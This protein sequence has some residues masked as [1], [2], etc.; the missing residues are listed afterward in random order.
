M[1]LIL[2]DESDVSTNDVVNWLNYFSVYYKR[3]NGNSSI[4][5][6]NIYL[7]DEG[8]KWNLTITENFNPLPVSISSDSISQFWYRRG[9][10]S[11]NKSLTIS[12]NFSPANYQVI[13]ELQRCINDNQNDVIDFLYHNLQSVKS[14]G[15]WYENDTIKIVNLQIAKQTGLLIPPTT[16]V[17][18]K[19]ELIQFLHKHGK[20]ITKGINYNGF[21]LDRKLSGGCGTELIKEEDIN[22]IAETFAPSLIQKYLEKLFEIRIFYIDGKCYSAAIFSQQ[23]EKT[24]IDFRNYNEERPNRIVPYQLPVDIEQKLVKFMNAIE[25]KSG[26]IDLIVSPQLDYIFLEVNPVGQFGWISDSCNY[27]IDKVIASYFRIK[28]Y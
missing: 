13:D 20:C 5:L 7:S 8:V 25:M 22:N 2:S 19:E 27:T 28:F 9:A 21:L 3:V 15:S 17:N 12:P 23:D 11:I 4:N 10:L 6:K 1:L 14:I 16:I 24:K 26:S 18:T